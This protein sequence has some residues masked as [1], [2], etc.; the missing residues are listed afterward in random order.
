MKPSLIKTKTKQTKTK[1]KQTQNFISSSTTALMMKPST[2]SS[3]F[4]L[5]SSVSYN[6][7]V[8]LLWNALS[9][10]TEGYWWS[11]NMTSLMVI[12]QTPFLVHLSPFSVISFSLEWLLHSLCL[13]KLPPSVFSTDHMLQPTWFLPAPSTT[14]FPKLSLSPLSLSMHTAFCPWHSLLNVSLVSLIRGFPGVA[15]LSPLLF[16]LT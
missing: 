2:V 8:S 4:G 14:L 1:I 9:A 7:P 15:S 13:P 16:F 12:S 6:R 10:D 11:W 3:P 5:C